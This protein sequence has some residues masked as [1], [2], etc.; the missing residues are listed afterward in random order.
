M[1]RKFT[2]KINGI[3]LHKWY[4]YNE[5]GMQHVCPECGHVATVS[6]SELE[7]CQTLQPRGVGMFS[8]MYEKVAPRIQCVKCGFRN[9]YWMFCIRKYSK[10]LTIADVVKNSIS[11]KIFDDRSVIIDSMPNVHRENWV[12]NNLAKDFEGDTIDIIYLTPQRGRP[13]GMTKSYT[14]FGGYSK[15][16]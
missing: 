11:K 15:W 3:L 9:P 2:V 14:N 4:L 8:R 16:K 12:W 5:E 7:L 6:Q 10:E 1:E 13:R